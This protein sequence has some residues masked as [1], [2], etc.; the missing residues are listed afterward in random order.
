MIK[1][2]NDIILSDDQQ[3]YETVLRNTDKIL[4]INVE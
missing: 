3:E 2:A 1:I 4:K